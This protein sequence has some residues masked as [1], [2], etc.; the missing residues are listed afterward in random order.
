MILIRTFVI[1]FCLMATNSCLQTGEQTK[2]LSIP[3]LQEKY[4]KSANTYELYTAGRGL[5]KAEI[6]PNSPLVVK[7]DIE[8]VSI[9]YHSPKE[10]IA[11]GGRVTVTYPPGSTLPQLLHKDSAGYVNIRAENVPVNGNLIIVGLHR[12]AEDDAGRNNPY[13]S[14]PRNRRVVVAGLPDGLPAGR[15]LTFTWSKVSIDRYARRFYGD[16]LLFRVYADHDADGFAEEIKA[17]PSIPKMAD[18]PYRIMLRCNSTV[19]VGESVKMNILALDKYDNPA[20]DYRGK[21]R[22]HTHQEHAQLPD[23]YIFTE[24]D[25]ASHEFYGSFEKPGFY[26]VEAIDEEHNFHARSN[27]IQV[28]EEEPEK[29]L[30]WGDLHVHTDMSSDARSDAHTTATYEG[31]YLIGRYRYALDFQANTDHH[32]LVDMDYGAAHWE[33]MKEIT[34]RANDPGHFVTLVANELSHGKGDQNVYFPGDEAPFLLTSGENHPYAVWDTLAQYECFTV[35]HHVAQSMRPW[36]W[37]NF[38]PALM[39]VVEIFSNHGRAEFHGNFP[40]FSHHPEATLDG[41]TW[42]DQLNTGKKLGAIASSD[43]HWARPGTIGL[44]GVWASKL[45]REEIYWQIKRRFC[46]ASTAARV[47]LYYTVNGE[48]MG[49]SI[50]SHGSP[51]IEVTAASPDIIEKA[52]IV[53][54]GEVAYLTEPDSLL[55]AF[56][57]TDSLFSDSAYYYVRLTLRPDT[58][59]EEYMKNRQQF[60]WSSPVWVSGH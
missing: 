14:H 8:K 21:V 26:W 30:Y 19:V 12:K 4:R 60:I 13:R 53:K 17:S 27:P 56:Q 45:D 25:R 42:V 15:K 57:W 2:Q 28:F 35:P 16:R 5:G 38:N 29:R 47:I 22:F 1:L 44:T 41:H 23:S 6:I 55:T 3:E 51:E 24:D 9:T 18:I 7:Q 59:A 33:E 20:L 54:N 43:D 49:S 52:E 32:S 10:G 46:Y 48:E 11:P 37:E 39:K 40:H 58:N 31:S 36:Q 34:N 50:H